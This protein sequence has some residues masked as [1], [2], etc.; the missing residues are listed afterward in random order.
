MGEDARGA[1]R[2]A[3]AGLEDDDLVERLA[4]FVLL[5]DGA[6][7]FLARPAWAEAVVGTRF[8]GPPALALARHGDGI[9]VDLLRNKQL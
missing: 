4:A 9:L 6:Q 3:L 5:A 8:D 1:V 2:Q 7:D